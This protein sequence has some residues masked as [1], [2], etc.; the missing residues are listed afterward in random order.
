[1]CIVTVK[2]RYAPPQQL[3]QLGEVRRY[4][5]RQP[6]CGRGAATCNLDVIKIKGIV[7]T[8]K[9]PKQGTRLGLLRV[10]CLTLGF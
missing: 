10:C 7:A 4:A 9:N 8:K 3:R 6:L 1:M 2:R 5:P